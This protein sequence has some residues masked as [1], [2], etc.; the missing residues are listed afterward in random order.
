[1]G[2]RGKLNGPKRRSVMINIKVLTCVVAEFV[3]MA[4]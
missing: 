2:R 4:Q 3:A 1:M